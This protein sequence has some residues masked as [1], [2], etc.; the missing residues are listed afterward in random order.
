MGLIK[1]FNFCI[2]SS[3]T[4]TNHEILQKEAKLLQFWY[5]II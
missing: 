3:Y 5:K 4:Y 2:T 1:F